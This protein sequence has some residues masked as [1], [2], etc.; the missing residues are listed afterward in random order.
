MAL[1]RPRQRSQNC[2]PRRPHGNK[3]H[4]AGP[5]PIRTL[6]RLFILVRS[7]ISGVKGASEYGPDQQSKIVNLDQ[8]EPWNDL[9]LKKGPAVIELWWVETGFRPENPEAAPT[10]LHKEQ[11]TCS[12][13][14]ADDLLAQLRQADKTSRRCALPSFPTAVCPQQLA[15]TVSETGSLTS[16]GVRLDPCTCARCPPAVDQIACREYPERGFTYGAEDADGDRA[17]QEESDGDTASRIGGATLPLQPY[18]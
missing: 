1:L 10:L 13:K 8:N 5:R 17:A 16:A 11:F 6:Q 14:L 15:P 4:T 9:S 12:F 18:A 3:A 7:K 2:L